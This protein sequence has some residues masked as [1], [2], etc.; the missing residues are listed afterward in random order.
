LS[1]NDKLHTSVMPA[2][3]SPVATRLVPASVNFRSRRLADSRQSTKLS[4]PESKQRRTFFPFIFASSNSRSVGKPW[5]E[6][7]AVPT[8]LTITKQVRRSQDCI[9][10][11]FM[12]SY[13]SMVEA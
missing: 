3:T 9:G 12:Q 11:G 4:V 1:N 6:K 10:G 5:H 7:Q 2:D 8:Q 13:L